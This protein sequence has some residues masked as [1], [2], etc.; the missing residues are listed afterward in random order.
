MLVVD[1]SVLVEVAI[2]NAAAETTLRKLGGHR[3][4]APELIDAEIASAL[5]GHER[6]G[7]LE[8]DAATAF[9]RSLLA[10]PLRRVSHR[11]LL[12]DAWDLRHRLS[13]YD[14]FY[15]ALARRL[16]A[17]IVTCDRRWAAA[18]DLG[19]TVITVG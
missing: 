16:D 4:V 19:V 1:A 6:A 8:R 10:V 12:Q 2:G 14:A 3:P 18:G 5:K 13:T 7:R 15:L 17:P 11:L 9:A